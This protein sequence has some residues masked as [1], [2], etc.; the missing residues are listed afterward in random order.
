M[1]LII[2]EYMTSSHSKIWGHSHKD[3]SGK[4][5]WAII[6]RTSHPKTWSTSGGRRRIESLQGGKWNLWKLLATMEWSLRILANDFSRWN[7]RIG[8][9]GMTR[10]YGMIARNLGEWLFTMEWSRGIFG[11]DLLPERAD[12]RYC[13]CPCCCSVNELFTLQSS[14]ASSLWSCRA[15]DNN[16]CAEASS[17]WSFRANDWI[18]TP[19]TRLRCALTLPAAMIHRHLLRWLESH[20]LRAQQHYD[21]RQNSRPKFRIIGSN[22]QPSWDT[23]HLCK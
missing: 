17:L 6:S 8:S 19:T 20:S 21:V 12:L 15:H 23:R 13:S 7:D 5:R 16:L 11:N 14:K 18:V 1:R 4:S 9:L 22:K 2:L 10:Y 3:P